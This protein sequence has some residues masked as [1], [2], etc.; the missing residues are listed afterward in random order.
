MDGL[1]DLLPHR[2]PWLLVDRVVSRSETRVE[3]EKRLAAGDPLLGDGALPELL[4]VEALAQAAACLASAERGRHRG[5]LV[6]ATAFEFHERAQAGETVRLCATRDATLGTLHRFTVEA[7]AGERV[8]AK[9][10]L[11]FA[12]EE[13][14]R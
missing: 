10:R 12:L 13:D 11:T 14:R 6:A 4:V 7:R 3:C 5:M 2:P 8:I 9:G 1:V